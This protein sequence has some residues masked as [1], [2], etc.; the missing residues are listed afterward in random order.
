MSHKKCNGNT[1][2]QCN[3]MQTE[4]T[5]KTKEQV[6]LML[7]SNIEETDVGVQTNG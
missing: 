6:G 4:K 7:V 3:A 5:E 1:A 2:M